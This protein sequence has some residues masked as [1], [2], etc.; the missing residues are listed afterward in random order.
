M[1]PYSIQMITKLSK[2][3]FPHMKPY[4]WYTPCQAGFLVKA[5]LEKFDVN[6]KVKICNDGTMFLE[7][8]VREDDNMG[9]GQQSQEQKEKPVKLS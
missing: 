6:Y 4:E 3:L 7:D 2:E 1:T 9:E 8:I 5:M